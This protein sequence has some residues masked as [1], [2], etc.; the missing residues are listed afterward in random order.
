PNQEY[1]VMWP[2]LP[3]HKF[4]HRDHRF[5]WTRA[6]FQTWATNVAETYGYTFSISPI[7]P[8]DEVVGAPSQMAV[9]T[10]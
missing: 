5:E 10:R 3:A 4:R 8:E 6:E 2:S 9:F 1:N 7:G